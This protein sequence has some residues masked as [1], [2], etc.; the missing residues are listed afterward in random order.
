MYFE[1]V[2]SGFYEDTFER[3]RLLVKDMNPLFNVGKMEG[4]LNAYKLFYV[5]CSRAK[6]ELSGLIDMNQLK[7]E[8]EKLIQKFDQCG[9]DVKGK[10]IS[11]TV[12]KS[13]KD[14]KDHDR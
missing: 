12:I 1:L 4:I 5:G 2:Y 9:F 7:G 8:R 6:R 13:F 10:E 14:L 11:I 3:G